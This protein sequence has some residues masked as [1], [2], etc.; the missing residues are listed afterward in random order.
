[1]EEVRFHIGYFDTLESHSCTRDESFTILLLPFNN[2]LQSELAAKVI[3]VDDWEVSKATMMIAGLDI[4][5]LPPPDE[6]AVAA[7]VILRLPSLEVV[8]EDI[9]I[10]KPPIKYISGYLGFRECPVYQSLLSK[11][12][13]SLQPEVILVHGFGTLHPRQC[14]AA[15]HLGVLTNIPTIGV[16]KNV[17]NIGNLTNKSVRDTVDGSQSNV[18]LLKI[19][20][21]GETISS[22]PPSDSQPAVVVGAAV[23]PLGCS[24]PIYVSIGHRVSLESAVDIVLKCCKYRIPEPIRQADLRS[25]QRMMVVQ[26]DSSLI[27]T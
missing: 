21:D 16:A 5:P 15:S 11:I 6:R 8:Y 24:R 22:S 3:H 14:G 12:P 17:L 1:M 7:V 10:V 9:Q 2:R 4:T 27:N 25:R 18:V 23:R 19:D 13:S 20:K 26:G